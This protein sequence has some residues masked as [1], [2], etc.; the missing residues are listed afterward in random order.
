MKWLWV[1]AAGCCASSRASVCDRALVS[2]IPIIPE[3]G[4]EPW[5]MVR[6]VNTH[7]APTIMRAK[8]PQWKIKFQRYVHPL[9]T[10]TPYYLACSNHA[11]LSNPT[12]PHLLPLPTLDTR[13]NPNIPSLLGCLQIDSHA[14][15][16]L[17]YQTSSP[18][19]FYINSKA[20]R[21]TALATLRG[22]EGLP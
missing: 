19:S 6:T 10:L 8:F 3:R 4:L 1:N 2:P 21:T 7:K 15:V 13:V 20:K 11:R 14:L 18:R 22:G 17:L 12:Q 9:L 5:G 16:S